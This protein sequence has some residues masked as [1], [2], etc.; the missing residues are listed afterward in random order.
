MPPL[1]PLNMQSLFDRALKYIINILIVYIILVLILGLSKTIYSSTLMIS[2]RFLEFQLSTV[3]TDILTFL[4]IIEL[5]K[6]FVEYFK[7]ERF[8]LHTMLD[9]A[10]IFIVR[11]LIV[12][13][14]SHEN[15]TNQVL[16]GFAGLILCIG[17][18]RTLAVV[19]S[20]K[21]EKG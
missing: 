20:P 10:I 21:D 15:M 9:P 4:V 5:F 2:G 11:E 14:Y 3:V 12:K 8:R 13:L 19:Y 18:I 7:A 1:K 6:S 17:V 16:L